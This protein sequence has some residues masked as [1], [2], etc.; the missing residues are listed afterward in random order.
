MPR[1]MQCTMR[2]MV[3]RTWAA[4]RL[5]VRPPDPHYLQVGKGCT[6]L[7]LLDLVATGVFP[8]DHVVLRHLGVRNESTG[9]GSQPA[10]ITAAR[11]KILVVL[12]HPSSEAIK[13]V[14]AEC[15]P[16]M[17]EKKSARQRICGNASEAVTAV[18]H[19]LSPFDLSLPMF[20]CFR[21]RHRLS[22]SSSG[23]FCIRRGPVLRLADFVL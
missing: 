21:F 2:A 12:L 13:S 16:V 8:P 18:G 11:N 7:S 9:S 17:D 20:S 5:E 14:V 1:H 10:E 3:R 22:F 6:P 19:T 23:L 15:T 4:L